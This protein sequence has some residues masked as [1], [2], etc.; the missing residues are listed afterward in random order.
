MRAQRLISLLLLLQ[1]RSP[2]TGG[3]LAAELGVSLR[4]VQRDIEALVEAGVPLSASRGMTGGYSLPPGYHSRLIGFSREEAAALFMAGRPGPPHELG[5]GTV[6][7]S[8]QLKILGSMPAELR[9]EAS[10]AAQLFHLDSSPWFEREDN[11]P[12]D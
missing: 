11:S 10:R 2:L 12:F 1:S 3:Q 9:D 5:L 4:T 8:A 7:A 6:F